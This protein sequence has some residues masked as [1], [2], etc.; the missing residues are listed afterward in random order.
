MSP[1]SATAMNVPLPSPRVAGDAAT[2]AMRVDK[3]VLVLGGAT[4]D[5]KPPPLVLRTMPPK[6]S[7]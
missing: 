4:V 1:D 2:S 6:L 3:P 7:L 5:Q